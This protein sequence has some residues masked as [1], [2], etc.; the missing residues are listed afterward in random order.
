MT[1]ASW[2]Q[3]SSRI[4]PDERGR[5]GGRAG[6]LAGWL[7]SWWGA[8]LRDEAPYLEPAVQVLQVGCT[9]AGQAAV[10]GEFGP[11]HGRNVTLP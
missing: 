10:R 4:R 8:P 6:W 7:A 5:A 2:Q 11:E 3:L 9:D 1:T